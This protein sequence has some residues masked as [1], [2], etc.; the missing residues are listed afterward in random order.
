M[1]DGDLPAAAEAAAS[2]SQ[3]HRHTVSPLPYPDEATQVC[4]M[5]NSTSNWEPA[6]PDH[7][8]TPVATDHPTMPGIPPSDLYRW[9]TTSPRRGGQ[10]SELR[11][12]DFAHCVIEAIGRRVRHR[13][14]YGMTPPTSPRPPA[15]RRCEELWTESL[16]R[17][18]R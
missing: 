15:E 11:A 9:K 14:T 12:V 10:A 18:C 17:R 7:V 8:G 5:S 6:C 16:P 4:T 1:S 2:S 3:L 13:S